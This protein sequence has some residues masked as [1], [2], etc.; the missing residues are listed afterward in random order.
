MQPLY[1]TRAD[2]SSEA[3][4]IVLGS[5]YRDERTQSSLRELNPF[6][7]HFALNG[8]IFLIWNLR[9]HLQ[10]MLG[11]MRVLFVFVVLGSFH[12]VLHW[13]CLTKVSGI[14][15]MRVCSKLTTGAN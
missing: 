9:H 8:P 11:V 14:R 1:Q 12:D 7:R 6:G 10:T 4:Y 5:F 2:R 13:R 15:I 3:A